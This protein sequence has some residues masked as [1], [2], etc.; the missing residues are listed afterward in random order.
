MRFTV[1][2]IHVYWQEPAAAIFCDDIA[3]NSGKQRLLLFLASVSVMAARKWYCIVLSRML[4]ALMRCC[5]PPF[6]SIGSV[7]EITLKA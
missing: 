3:R 1:V 4:A 6:I 5:Q 2:H 7:A